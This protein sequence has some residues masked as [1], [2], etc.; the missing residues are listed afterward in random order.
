M[1]NGPGDP[2]CL[3]DYC[4]TDPNCRR[5][6]VRQSTVDLDHSRGV[7]AARFRQ[8]LLDKKLNLDLT[9]SLEIRNTALQSISG[10]PLAN[11]GAVSLPD[12]L[13]DKLLS[14]NATGTYNLRKWASVG[15]GYT[16]RSNF[17]KDDVIVDSSAGLSDVST[18][19]SYNQH[20]VNIF[21]RFV[22]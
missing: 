17:T 5:D 16:L 3:N 4:A 12:E 8:M 18:G 15:A 9:G 7:M 6:Q 21:A 20:I 2:N 22:Y 19:R 14:I 13:D 11:G 1:Q 10:I